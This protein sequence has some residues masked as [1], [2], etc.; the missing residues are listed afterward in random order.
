M[1]EVISEKGMRLVQL[2]GG[3][4]HVLSDKHRVI[5][6]LR[7]P[8]IGTEPDVVTAACKIGVVLDPIEAQR[9]AGTLASAACVQ[10]LK[11]GPVKANEVHLPDWEL[12]IRDPARVTPSS[13]AHVP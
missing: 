8:K 12:R 7:S 5:I 2:A 6:Q 9:L 10:Q 3:Q 1:A 13:R 11:R 4:L